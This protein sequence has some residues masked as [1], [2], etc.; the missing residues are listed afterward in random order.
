VCL[1]CLRTE[2]AAVGNSRLN[3]YILF[4]LYCHV[5]IY[6]IRLYVNRYSFISCMYVPVLVAVRSK[7][8]VCGR[9]LAEIVGSNPTRGMDVCLLC[10]VS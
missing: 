2:I 3:K 5:F 10:V 1:Y 7:A 9:S 6:Y 4:I 8:L